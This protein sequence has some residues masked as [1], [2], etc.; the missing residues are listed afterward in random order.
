MS[1]D[2]K[3]SI[4]LPRNR[5]LIE[6]TNREG[7]V[8]NADYEVFRDSVVYAI[9]QI[10]VE[11]NLDKTRIRNAYRAS[12]PREPVLEDLNELR[13][14]VKR[15]NLEEEIDP[16]LNRIEADYVAIRERLLSE[17]DG[18]PQPVGSDP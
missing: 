6:K 9:Q 2:I 4:D 13:E 8:E 12:A 16:F 14:I 11:R 10:E 18:W 1:L 7:F 3:K 17:R 5:G 15:R